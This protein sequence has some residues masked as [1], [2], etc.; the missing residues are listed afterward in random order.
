M[1]DTYLDPK[2]NTYYTPSTGYTP[3]ADNP[4]VNPTIAQT[5]PVTQTVDTAQPSPTT[6]NATPYTSSSF[7]KPETPVAGYDPSTIFNDKNEP[8]SKDQY[9]AQGGKPDF[10]NVQTVS[11]LKM[12]FNKAVQSGQP[13][14][15]TP[16][17]AS[18]VIKSLTPTQAQDTSGIETQLAADPGY[19]QL[20]K[21]YQEYSKTSNQS[22]TLVDQY[23]QLTKDSGLDQINT[24]LLNMK[25]VIDGTEDDIR[26]EVKAANGFATDS[27]VLGLASARNKTLIKNYNA[28]VDQA[29]NIKSQISTMVTLASQDRDFALNSITQKLKIDEEINNYRQKFVDNAKEAYNNVIKTIGYTGLYQSLKDD[30]NSLALA[31]RTLG[32]S[33]GQLQT[34]G[35]LET[36]KDYQIT[37]PYIVTAK[38]EVQ[39]TQT[40]EA[41]VS[42]QDFQARTGMSLDQASKKGL[43]KPLGQ[44]LTQQKEALD[45]SLKQSQITQNNAQT[46]KIM[47]DMNQSP[48]IKTEVIDLGNGHKQLINSQTGEVVKDYKPGDSVSTPMQQA[49]SKSQIDQIANILS[50]GNLKTSVGPNSL[51]RID[52]GSWR[53]VLTP[54]AS[55]FVADVEQLRQGLTLENLQNAKANG[56]TFGALSEGELNL[57]TQSASKLGTWAVKDK[58]GNVVGYNAKESDFRKELDKINNFAKLDYVLKGGTPADVG[59]QQVNGEWVSQNSDGTVQVFDELKGYTPENFKEAGKPQASTMRTDRHNNPTAFTTD[60]AKLGG[61]KEGVDYVQGDSFSNGQYH[62]AKLLGDPVAATV[63]VIDKIGFYTASGKPRWTY[64][65][66]IPE[67]KNWNNLSYDQKKNVIAQMYQHEGGSALKQYFA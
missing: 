15:Q 18:S 2:S 30:P 51:S 39:N 58:N 37:T 17:E 65:K 45:L 23:K 21:D 33:S 44:S 10:S 5:S 8:L 50:S 14:P 67:A 29:T 46:A 40:G 27:Q 38:G 57:L 56:A 52:V 16:G 43:L 60:I 3:P 9:L 1:S 11:A 34:L 49:Q 41:Y 26:N 20:L 19:Q 53:G 55:N 63:K 28:L 24:D 61:L 6:V 22:Q 7:Y 4:V 48:D 25:K 66:D 35:N 62:T 47:Y 54:G 32:F 36:L 64:V 59:L 31:E 42:P 12:G 13:A